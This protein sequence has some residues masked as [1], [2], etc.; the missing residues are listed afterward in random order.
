MAN[1][2]KVNDKDWNSLAGDDQARI[3]NLVA[4][5]FGEAI[6]PDANE[7]S[8][9]GGGAGTLSA[10]GAAGGLQ[11]QGIWCKL[12]CEAARAVAATGCAALSG[13][14]VAVCLAGVQAG[15]Q[16]CISKC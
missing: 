6:T 4:I 14:A 9:G 12:G 16:F 13:P 2:I 15:Y 3:S 8:V 7:P 1:G 11:A 10:G 5:S